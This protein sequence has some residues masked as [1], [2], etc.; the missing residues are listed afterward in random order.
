MAFLPLNTIRH[1]VR[2]TSLVSS[3]PR[4]NGS[5]LV[6]GTSSLNSSPAPASPD[7]HALCELRHVDT[8]SHVDRPYACSGI[9][10]LLHRLRQVSAPLQGRRI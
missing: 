4:I 6:S 10:L 3:I 2:M 5:R 7:H 1:V 8:R 9:S